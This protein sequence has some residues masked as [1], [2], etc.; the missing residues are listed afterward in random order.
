[1]Q[2]QPQ[3]PQQ[4]QPPNQFTQYP[5]QQQSYPPPQYRPP[6]PPPPLRP[7]KTRKR[8]WVGITIAFCVLVIILVIAVIAIGGSQST[9]PS[10]AGFDK[11]SAVFTTVATLDKDGN[12]DKGKSVHFTATL[13]SFVKDSNG[14][15]AG[16][17][18]DDPSLN[19]FAAVQVSFPDGTDL[20][21]LN[22]GDTLEIWGVDG[23]V[24]SGQN[25]FGGTVSEV[26]IAS[27]Y[28]TDRTTGYSV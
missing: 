11:A 19:S 7:N 26:G 20:S 17:N 15:T 25:A 9:L 22:T 1:M 27:A 16:A 5:P 3:Q 8:V 6:M 2:D 13:G 10:T 12:S 14:N 4:E 28:M 24:Y 23:G 21:R 18:V